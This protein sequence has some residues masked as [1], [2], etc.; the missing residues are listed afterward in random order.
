VYGPVTRSL[1]GGSYKVTI[2]TSGSVATITSTGYATV[3]ATGDQVSRVVQVVA[4]NQPLFNVALGAASDVNM[5]G[6]STASDSWNSHDPNESNGGLYNGYSGTNGSVASEDGFVDI[7]NHTIQ[8]N[9]YLGPTASYN[10]SGTIDGTVYDDYNVQFPDAALP[11]TDL[12]GLPIVWLTPPPTSSHDFT[13]SGYYTISDSKDIT[14]EAGQTVVVDL[15]TT[16]FDPSYITIMG[17]TTNAGT[18]IIYQESGTMT[19]GGHSS[20]GAIDN[21]PENFLY[22]GLPGVTGISLSGT[23]TFVGAIYA[24]EASLTLNGGGNSND[25]EGS[26]IVKQVTLNGHYDFHYDESLAAY[27]P[28]RGYVPL[29]WQEIEN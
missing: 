8:G 12:T 11:T 16:T 2:S 1:A 19:L 15:K 22:Y 9:L 29:S 5:N 14:V 20:G 6:N 17:G 13:T 3:P 24:P 21:K 10:N 23:S 27:G 28:T 25:L 26:A 18:L 4:E 7:G